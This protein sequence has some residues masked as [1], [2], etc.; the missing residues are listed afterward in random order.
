MLA[1][2]SSRNGR[3][4]ENAVGHGKS[5]VELVEGQAKFWLNEQRKMP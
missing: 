3:H 1:L 4:A 5:A 2:S